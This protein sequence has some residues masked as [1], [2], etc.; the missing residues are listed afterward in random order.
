MTIAFTPP[1]VVVPSLS[2]AGAPDVDVF[3]RY[4]SHVRS[5]CRK[6]PAVFVRAKGA[7]LYAED[8]RVFT[9]FFC[10]A[11]SLNYGHN[12]D[13]IKARI[14]DYLASDGMM[15]GLDMYTAA[16]R[17]FLEA[18]TEHILRPRGLDY[19]VQFSGPTGADAVEAALKLARK[20]TGR[21]GVFAFG[22]GY[23]GM[24]RGSL[25]VTG[26]GRARRAGGVH[27]QDEVTFIPYEDGPQGPFDSIALIERLLADS[28][29]GVEAPAA[30]IVEPLQMEGGVYPASADWLRR[31]RAV[32]ER[33]GI[34]LI[35]DEIQSGCGRT[36][37]FFA[38]EES[39]IVP[40][41]VTVSKSISGYGLPLALTLFR[42]GLDVWEPGEHT[43]TFRG[44]QLAFV[45]A[46]AAAE[47]WSDPEFVERLPVPARSLTALGTELTAAEPEITVRGRGMVLGIDLGRAGGGM[48]AEEVQRYAFEHGLIVELSGRDDEVIKILPPLTVTPEELDHGIG[49][50]RAALLGR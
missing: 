12:P 38:F 28:S 42:P 11:G 45:A 41:M 40:D 50:L 19:T 27:G 18:L 4:E 37:T 30:V 39:G 2:A 9:D 34:L 13:P 23:H 36:G 47:L 3:E 14:T 25:A 33:H 26:N 49:V 20:A 21:R 16:K 6:F 46:T 22:G 10:G 15:H 24:T 8:G 5:Y 48:R 7:R 43:G 44:N 29:S 35:C 1:P 32:T 17:S 31:L